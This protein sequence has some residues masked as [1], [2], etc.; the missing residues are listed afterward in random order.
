MVLFYSIYRYWVYKRIAELDSSVYTLSKEIRDRV[1]LKRYQ[2]IFVRAYAYL[3]GNGNLTG[4]EYQLITPDQSYNDPDDR[5]YISPYE[6]NY[7]QVSSIILEE[8]NFESHGLYPSDD[9]T[10]R[11]AV[12]AGYGYILKSGNKSGNTSQTSGYYVFDIPFCEYV[13]LRRRS[14]ILAYTL[15]PD[16]LEKLAPY[17]AGSVAFA[18][19]VYSLFC[20]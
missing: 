9:R 2:N 5:G 14:D 7:W 6:I 19:G 20:S 17:I 11:L 4:F 13:T 8:P 10:V 15:L 1:L 3:L 16:F 12:H 18:I